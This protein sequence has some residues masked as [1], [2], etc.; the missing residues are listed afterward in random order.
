M[1]FKCTIKYSI[2]ATW[3]GHQE[4]KKKKNIKWD[5]LESTDFVTLQEQKTSL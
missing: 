4:K 1:Y 5:I 3:S 2:K